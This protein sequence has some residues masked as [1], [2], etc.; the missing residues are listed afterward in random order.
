VRWPS[1]CESNIIVRQ[2]P[3]D[4]N[5]NTEAENIVGIRHQVT[6]S[7]DSRVRRLRTSC[8]EL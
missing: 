7:E 6:T 5:V 3:T 2:P 4:K 8:S 1:D